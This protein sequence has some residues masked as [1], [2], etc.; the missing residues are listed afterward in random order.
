MPAPPESCDNTYGFASF[1]ALGNDTVGDCTI[2][3]LMHAIQTWHLSL[4]GRTLLPFG[5]TVAIHY[6]SKWA[7]YVPGQPSTDNGAVELDVLNLWRK[8]TINDHNLKA[9]CDPSPG[10]V[11]HIKKA[12]W[13]F[14]GAYIGIDFPS[15]VSEEPGSVWDYDP[16]A[17][18]L[19]GHAVWCPGYGPQGVVC[20]S[21]GNLYTMTWDFWANLT[22]E[23]HCLMSD[24]DFMNR[25]QATFDYRALLSDLRLVSA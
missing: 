25:D 8:S 14:G 24:T 9:F 5:D 13:A 15:N 7:G 23:S 10:N 18:I 1:G 19:G 20:I 12:I 6:Y 11:D 16:T 2:A 4:V 17:S 21:W 22:E 3:A